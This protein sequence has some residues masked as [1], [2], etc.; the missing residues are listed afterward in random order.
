MKQAHHYVVAAGS[1]QIQIDQC[2]NVIKNWDKLLWCLFLPVCPC[3]KSKTL[4]SL[5][6]LLQCHSKRT[7]ELRP[8]EDIHRVDARKDLTRMVEACHLSATLVTECPSHW[9]KRGGESRNKKWELRGYGMCGAC[10]THNEP[11]SSHSKKSNKPRDIFWYGMEGAAAELLSIWVRLRNVLLTLHLMTAL[12]ARYHTLLD[13]IEYHLGLA[14]RAS[15]PLAN[16]CMF[17]DLST[18]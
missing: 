6:Q 9:S 8:R 13:S 7:V 14:G 11:V 12:S 3:P 4:G 18:M 16:E 1:S 2:S 17:T 15:P 10:N 5:F